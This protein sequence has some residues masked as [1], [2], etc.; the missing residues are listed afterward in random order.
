[1]KPWRFLTVLLVTAF[2][3]IPVFQG[4]AAPTTEPSAQAGSDIH[5]AITTAVMD[6]MEKHTDVLAFQ[7]FH[8]QVYQIFLAEDEKQ[9]VIWLAAVDEESGEVVAAEPALAIANLVGEDPTQP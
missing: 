9:A 4:N 7:L 6:S 1:M 3:L 5:E 8:M 2:L